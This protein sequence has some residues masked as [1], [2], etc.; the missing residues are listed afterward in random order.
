M[1]E[2]L[3]VP[4]SLRHILC[5]SLPYGHPGR[6]SMLTTVESVVATLQREIVAPAR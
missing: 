5:W 1:G 3:V 2:R 6:D 4:L